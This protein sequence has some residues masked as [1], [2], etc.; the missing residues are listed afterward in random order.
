MVWDLKFWHF[1]CKCR[2][3]NMQHSDGKE[4]TVNG[5]ACTSGPQHDM[6][7]CMFVCF[8][9]HGMALLQTRGIYLSIQDHCYSTE[10]AFKNS[11]WTYT[12]ISFLHIGKNKKN[13]QGCPKR[14]C[15]NK[16]NLLENFSAA[17]CIK[18]SKT[19]ELRRAAYIYTILF[20]VTQQQQFL[21]SKTKQCSDTKELS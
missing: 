17:N 9:L 2:Q 18:L 19:K 3:H 13:F 11:T 16:E 21:W 4:Y 7:V 5:N 8:I 10:L 14:E 20:N 1:P 15:D 6:F 12:Q